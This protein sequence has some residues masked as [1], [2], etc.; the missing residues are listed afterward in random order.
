MS[1]QT[2]QRWVVVT[3]GAGGIGRAVC[4][5]LASERMRPIVVDVDADRGA[6][7]AQETG[8]SFVHCD[9][10]NLPAAATHLSGAVSSVAPRLAG[11]V[12]AAGIS[13]QGH[14]PELSLDEWD[15]VIRINMTA[16]LFVVQA[17]DGLLQRPGAAIVMITSAEAT[18][19][20]TT[21]TRSTPAYAAAKAGL[22]LITESLASDLAPEGIRVNAVA[23][24]YTRTPLTAGL[25]ERGAGAWVERVV[26]MGKWGEPEEM[27][28]AVLFLL[29]DRS[30]YV[31]G[32]SLVVDGGLTL[33]LT[34][35][36]TGDE[37]G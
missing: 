8:G 25:R 22:K 30:R 24:G 36:M 11:V 32:A 1:A 3:G 37:D 5:G 12:S 19:V 34:T 16:P 17:L 18:R 10:N 35:T 4:R 27:A 28:D 20:I 2:S 29:S 33:G 6:R 26:P 21:S 14:Y 9:L 31:S 15:R 23:P 13:S 7:V